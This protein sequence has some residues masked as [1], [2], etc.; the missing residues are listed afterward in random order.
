ML[1]NQYLISFDSPLLCR[2]RIELTPTTSYQRL[3][4]HRCSAY[5]KLTPEIDNMNKTIYI[6]STVAS[7]M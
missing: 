4:V 3:L 1:I 7:R 6:S 5:Y 2:Q